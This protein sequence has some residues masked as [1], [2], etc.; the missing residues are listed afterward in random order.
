MVVAVVY[1]HS[2]ADHFGGVRGVVDEA[3]VRAGTVPIIA[4]AGF[5]EHAVA[6][7]ST[8]ATP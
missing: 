5:L 1:S 2:H 7:T 4:P 3:D 8:P 6:E